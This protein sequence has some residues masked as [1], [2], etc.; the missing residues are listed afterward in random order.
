MA[1]AKF[2]AFLNKHARVPSDDL[3]DPIAEAINTFTPTEC[4]ANSLLQTMASRDEEKP[5]K[6]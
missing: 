4:K 6:F 5:A 1:F 2:K 3:S